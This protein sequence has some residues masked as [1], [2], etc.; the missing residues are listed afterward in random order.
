MQK[1]DK[2]APT[3][4]DNAANAPVKPASLTDDELDGVAGGGIGGVYCA[5]VTGLETPLGSASAFT[6]GRSKS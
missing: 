1:D 6:V 3:G 2:K 4:A 5:T